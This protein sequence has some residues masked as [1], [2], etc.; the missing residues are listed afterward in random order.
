MASNPNSP[1]KSGS[2]DGS[3]ARAMGGNIVANPTDIPVALGALVIEAAQLQA[4]SERNR[5][6]GSRVL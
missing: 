3:I 5:S 4:T 1:P 6:L 2:I